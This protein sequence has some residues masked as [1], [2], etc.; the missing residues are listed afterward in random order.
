[1]E[2]QQETLLKDHSDL[3]KGAYIAAIAS[4]A[5]ADHQASEEEVEY[6][7]ALGESAGLSEAQKQLVAKAATEVTG[8]ELKRALEVLKNSDLRFSLMTDLINFAK[9]DQHYSDEERANIQQMA[10]QLNI[11]QE[12]FSLLNEFT[13]KTADKQLE[14]G[15]TE[16]SDFLSSI[17]LGGLKEKLAKSGINVGTLG[18]GL[19]AIAGPIILGGLLKRGLGGRGGGSSMLGNAL[20]GLGGVVGIGS[21]IGMLNGGRGFSNTGGLLSKVLGMGRQTF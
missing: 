15:A 2:Q 12:Q 14:P 17:G 8:D 5:T 18:K 16:S 11:N 4:L 7:V 19:L 10:Q 3:E 9:A 1:M 20:G 6:L 21:L 13:S